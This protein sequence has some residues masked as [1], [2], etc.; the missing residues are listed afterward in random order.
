VDTVLNINAAFSLAPPPTAPTDDSP[1]L[2]KISLSP[3]WKLKPPWVRLDTA[4]H[5][6]LFCK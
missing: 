1:P 3:P 6:M 4:F 5:F 2:E